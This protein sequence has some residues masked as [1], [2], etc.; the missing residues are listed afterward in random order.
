M[1]KIKDGAIFLTLALSVSSKRLH[2]RLCEGMKL[3]LSLSSVRIMVVKHEKCEVLVHCPLIGFPVSV[4]KCVENT[5][6]EECRVCIYR[7]K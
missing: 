4:S 5:L 7:S 3:K 1:L 2:Q 6:L